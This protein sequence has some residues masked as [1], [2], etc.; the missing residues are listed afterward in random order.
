MTLR[1]HPLEESTLGF[2][3]WP[4]ERGPEIVRIF[5][6]VVRDAPDTLG[7]GAVYLTGPEGEDF[8]PEHLIGR[9]AMA[10]VLVHAGSEASLRELAAPLFDAAPDGA[11]VA[12]LPYAELQSA[13]DDPPGYRNYWSAEHLEALPDEAVDAFCAQAAGMIVPSASQ[14]VLFTMGGAIAR[15]PADG[16]TRRPGSMI[17]KETRRDSTPKLG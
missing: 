1:L 15:G 10:I 4:P 14:H 3:L 13:L 5:R 6:D 16:C 12:E 11:M 7:G 8:V 9:L 17:I 2:L